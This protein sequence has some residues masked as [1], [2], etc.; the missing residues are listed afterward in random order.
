VLV[1]V[2][3]SS[4]A[5]GAL[6]SE[7]DFA[8]R[9]WT[10][11]AERMKRKREHR[12]PLSTAALAILERV[13]RR[14]RFV[15]PGQSGDKPVSDTALRNVLRDCGVDREAGSVHGMRS[16]CRDWMAD[17]DVDDSVAEAVLAHA[18]PSKVVA[19]YRRSDFLAKRADAME[20]W[21]CYLL[22]G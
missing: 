14:T 8:N 15:F 12:V 18:V 7:I 21:G 4:E 9:V 19:A 6:W 3:R 20:R 11:P 16:S 2:V 22:F 5:R 13:A 1:T 17:N 10:I